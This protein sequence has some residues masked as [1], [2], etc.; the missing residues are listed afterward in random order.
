[1]KTL[2]T[3]ENSHKGLSV[4]DGRA[5]PPSQRAALRLGIVYAFL[6]LLVIGLSIA[7]L[8]TGS[9]S[10]SVGEIF[11]TIAGRG[12]ET[13]ASILI[14]LRLPRLLSALILGG[15]LSVSGYLLQTYFNNALAGPFVLG[16]SSGAKLVVAIVMIMALDRGMLLNSW[17]MIGA[18]FLGAMVSMGFILLVSGFSQ[19]PAVLVISG[20]LIG[21]FCNAVTELFITFAKDTNIINLHTWSQGSFSGITWQNVIVMSVVC[22]AA[23]FMCVFLAKPMGAWQMGEAYALNLGVNVRALRVWMI[24]LSS[25]LSACVSAFAGPVAFVGIAVPHLTR[26]LLKT[27]K[28]PVL[29]PACFLGGSAFCLLADLIARNLFA[30]AEMSISV[31]T[32]VLGA[33]IVIMVMLRRQGRRRT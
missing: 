32:S 19:S 15:A 5:Q 26:S 30:P 29:L 20:V 18:A 11:E 14:D 2:H 10:M 21:Y 7:N 6:V 1:M 3:F 28:V 22:A 25:L 31:V 27:S 13:N 33:P 24:L 17:G 16:I 8:T 12:N 9:V 23:L 4:S